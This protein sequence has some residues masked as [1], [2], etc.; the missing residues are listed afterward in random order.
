MRET[1]KQ[2]GPTTQDDDALKLDKPGYGLKED[3]FGLE[4]DALL[5]SEQDAGKGMS[6]VAKRAP[7]AEIVE[8]IEWQRARKY[9]VRSIREWM[10]PTRATG[11]RTWAEVKKLTWA[12]L[13]SDVGSLAEEDYS[14]DGDEASADDDELYPKRLAWE[15]MLFSTRKYREK[16]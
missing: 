3:A 13:D 9:D 6:V 1:F 7:D 5:M 2:D 14:E 4:E 16:L 8:D 12:Q 11:A 10:E 15:R